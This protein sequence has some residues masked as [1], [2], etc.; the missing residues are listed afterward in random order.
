MAPKK[1]L[2]KRSTPYDPELLENWTIARLKASCR[3]RGINF[4]NHVRRFALVRLLREN[5]ANDNSANETRSGTRHFPSSQGA[6][7]HDSLGDVNQDGGPHDINNMVAVL[8]SLSQSVSILS[9]KV[10]NLEQKLQS[11]VPTTTGNTIQD[12]NYTVNNAINPGTPFVN[13]DTHVST[14]TTASSAT[15]PEF[16]LSSAYSAF[17]NIPSSPS[18]AAGSAEQLREHKYS[19]KKRLIVDMSAPHND[20][21]NPSLNSLID[22]DSHSLQYVKI[23]DAINL[24]KKLGKGTWLVKTDISD[25]FKLMP[26]KP[27]LWPLH[28]VS[29]NHKFYF[30]VR[31]VFGSRSSPKI[32]DSLSQAICW[33]AQ[34]VNKIDNVLHLLDD[35]LVLEPPHVDANATMEK[36]MAIFHKLS[37]PIAMHKTEGP[38]TCL[39]YLGVCL[40]SNNMEAR[41]P[42]EKVNRIRDIL[43]YF[44]LRKTCTKRELLSLLGHMNFASRVIRPGRS[45]VSHLIKLSTSVT[46]LHHHVHLNSAVRSDLAMWSSFLS[47]WNGVSFFLDDNITLAA[48]LEIFTDATPTSFGGFHRGNDQV[49]SFGTTCRRRS[50]TLPPFAGNIVGLKYDFSQW[51]DNSLISTMRIPGRPLAILFSVLLLINTVAARSTSDLY[52][53]LVDVLMEIRD[54]DD[55]TDG[56]KRGT[57]TTRD[58]SDTKKKVIEA[59]DYAKNYLQEYSDLKRHYYFRGGNLETFK[60]PIQQMGSSSTNY[61]YTLLS[62]P[63]TATGKV[64]AIVF[65]VRACNDAHVGLKEDENINGDLYEIVIGGWRNR[66]SVIRN[67]KQGRAKVVHAENFLLDCNEY[68]TFMVG[69]SGRNIQV[70][71]LTDSGWELFMQWQD[72]DNKTDVNFIGLTTARWATGHFRTPKRGRDIFID[73]PRTFDTAVYAMLHDHGFPTVQRPPYLMFEVMTC[74]NA[75]I[76]LFETVDQ[77]I[78]NGIEIVLGTALNTRSVIRSGNTILASAELDGVVNCDEY[79]AFMVSWHAGNIQVF[80]QTDGGWEQLLDFKLRGVRSFDFIGVTTNVYASGTW[81]FVSTFE[82]GLDAPPGDTSSETI[83]ALNNMDTAQTEIDKEEEAAL[84]AL[85]ATKHLLDRKVFKT[86]KDLQEDKVVMEF[87]AEKFQTSDG[88]CLSDISCD[89]DTEYR[90][91]NGECNNLKHHHWGAAHTPQN[92]LLPPDYDDGVNSPRTKS[93]D[94]SSILPSARKLSVEVFSDS[95]VFD[96]S[97]MDPPDDPIRSLMVM[98]W[99]QFTDHDVGE[100]PIS[101]GYNDVTVECCNVVDVLFRGKRQQCFTIPIDPSTDPA[102]TRDC[103]NFVRSVPART[104]PCKPGVREQ[105]NAITSYIDGSMIYGIRTR[106]CTISTS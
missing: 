68:R 62:S 26:I 42:M 46:E 81:R 86:L 82:I 106:C 83:A 72:T 75:H 7:S 16:T 105:L 103:M 12:R 20:P 100:T 78:Y 34:N 57:I 43:E 61:E 79:R 90:T 65:E 58:D 52:D 70:G 13:Q 28:G 80:R 69:W 36:F 49:Q 6:R 17:N 14:V 56:E 91:I 64:K 22:K 32:F 33:I 39:E 37:I 23:D 89:E 9:S 27:E 15:S 31:L 4:P 25:A 92:R 18:A 24:I 55:R 8:S 21:E 66:Q 1:R 2:N 48:D 71:K 5:G 19:K 50:N 41:L 3:D 45:F 73:T 59:F 51:W 104:N 40:D 85:I 10:D 74:R 38:C 11:T 93:V 84:I 76:G 102:F 101:K 53:E 35:F 30:F 95:S 54:S 98:V 87:W 77:D 97:V 99:G 63:E 60:T 29:W 94:G 96:P 47:S 88:D 67:V 44:S